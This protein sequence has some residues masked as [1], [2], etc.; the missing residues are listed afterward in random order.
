MQ[1]EMIT[2]EISLQKGFCEI[3]PF[4]VMSQALDYLLSNPIYCIYVAH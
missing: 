2:I 3:C 1:S 4:S